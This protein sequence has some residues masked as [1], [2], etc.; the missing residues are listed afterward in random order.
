M[1]SQQEIRQRITNQIVQALKEGKVP[2]WRSPWVGH[3]NAGLPTNIVSNKRY[4]G[5]N[6]LLLYLHQLRY[7]LKSKFFG[8]FNQ[9]KGI[10]AHVKPRP[11]EVPP[12]Q[13]GCPIIF[14]KPITKTERND[15]GEEVEVE[16]PVLRTYTVFGIDQ[17]EGAHLDRFRVGELSVNPDFIDYEPAEKAIAAIGADIRLGG[18]KAYYSR[19]GDFICCP[20]KHRFPKEHEFYAAL[21]HEL[22]HWSEGRLDWNGSYAEGELRAEIAAAFAL[23][24]LGVP[25]SDDLSNTQA[26][27]ASWISALSNDPKF[28]FRA[29]ADAN[30]VVDFLLAFG[31]TPVEEPEEVLAE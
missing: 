9:W 16:Y 4:R 2:P 12:G 27:V 3:P 26:Y 25:Q 18:E 28:I 19:N 7:G 30:K 8:T 31:R 11:S 15:D 17:V 5:I 24:E 20:H 1:P 13:W 6:V 10:A 14:Y 21:L 29:S 22:A 23:A